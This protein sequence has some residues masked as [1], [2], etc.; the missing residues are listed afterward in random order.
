M[1]HKYEPFGG[2]WLPPAL[3]FSAELRSN[4]LVIVSHF[5]KVLAVPIIALIQ[6]KS[7]I[8]SSWLFYFAPFENGLNYINYYISS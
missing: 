6:L 7:N 3:V 4:K 1:S 5:A 2:R 8:A